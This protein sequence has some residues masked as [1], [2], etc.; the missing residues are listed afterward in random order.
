MRDALARGDAMCRKVAKGH[1]WP[2]RDA[3]YIDALR[4]RPRSCRRARAENGQIFS[5]MCYFSE[6]HRRARAVVDAVEPGGEHVTFGLAKPKTGTLNDDG[7]RR[8][9]RASSEM[10]C[11]DVK[12]NDIV[13]DDA[14]GARER[15]H[16]VH[17]RSKSMDDAGAG[18]VGG[19]D[20]RR[21]DVDA[22]DRDDAYARSKNAR[23]LEM[24]PFARDNEVL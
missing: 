18:R 23:D 10:A 15:E 17:G 9:R 11:D 12:S 1:M 7:G 24:M 3:S 19:R 16:R 22:V 5:Y 8:M 2:P 21:R 20:A 14:C 13:R 4:R 6:E